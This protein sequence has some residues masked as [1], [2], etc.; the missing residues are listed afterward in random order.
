M[1]I[2]IDSLSGG[3]GNGDICKE[4]SCD[5]ERGEIL[6]VL[7]PNG[8]GKTT[9]FRLLLGFLPPTGGDIRINGR[10]TLEM[11]KKELAKLVAYIPQHHAPVFAYTVLE[12]I[13]MGR[14]SHVSA[15]DHPK[16]VDREKA[17][18]SMEKLHILHLANQ[19]YTSLSGGQRQM[20]LIAR[21]ICQDANIFVMDE[22]GANLDYANQQ[23]LVD[24]IVDLAEQGY[25]IIMSTHSPEQPFSIAHKVL[26]LKDGKNAAFG[27]PETAITSPVLERVYGIE[28]EVVSIVDRYEKK[29]TL[30]IPLHG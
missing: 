9:L 1:L 28:M 30:C 21:A 5:L 22:P 19:T 11:T 14:A 23:L 27:P 18:T 10:S 4:I 16:P 7:G 6:S 29:H 24:I 20:V 3:Y 12:I 2:E 17:F 13:M 8:C 25:G 15:F 26:L